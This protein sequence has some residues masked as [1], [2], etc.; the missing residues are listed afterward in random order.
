MVGLVDDST[1]V[2]AVLPDGT[3]VSSLGTAL[4]SGAAPLA[5]IAGWLLPDG[6]ELL[7]PRGGIQVSR[8]RKASARSTLG[9]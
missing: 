5:A 2:T 9:D 7:L 8:P 1:G 3:L 6:L 4:T